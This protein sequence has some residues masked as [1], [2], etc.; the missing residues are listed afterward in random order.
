MT[1]MRHDPRQNYGLQRLDR[2]QFDGK[3]LWKACANGSSELMSSISGSVVSML[4]NFQ[5]IRLA[6]EDGVAAYG[7]IMYVSFI[8][9]AIFIGYA[10]G[11]AP[12]ISFHCGA[13]HKDEL[14]S[15]LHKS[16]VLNGLAGAAMAALAIAAAVCNL[17]TSVRIQHFRLIL[18]YRPQ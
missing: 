14:R 10:I 12:V 17:L 5:L 2:P 15:L 6:G 9:A 3:T 4:Y 16:T 13:E 1:P 7:A 11:S 8:F 18:L